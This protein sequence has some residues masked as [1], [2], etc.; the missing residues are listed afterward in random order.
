MWAIIGVTGF[1]ALLI[2]FRITRRRGL[3]LD[4]YRARRDA[5]FQKQEKEMDAAAFRMPSRERLRIV[6][7]GLEDLLRL[8]GHPEGYGLNAQDDAL[9]AGIILFHTPAGQLHLGFVRRESLPHVQWHSRSAHCG[10]RAAPGLWRV[11]NDDR[12]EDFPSMEALM[13]RMDQFLRGGPLFDEEPPEYSRRFA[14]HMPFR[15]SAVNAVR[16]RKD[17]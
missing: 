1:A 11:W 15:G 6:H 4:G 7:A 12:G 8:A 16:R 5:D 10:A 3:S 13:R 9:R 17:P 14:G 2:S